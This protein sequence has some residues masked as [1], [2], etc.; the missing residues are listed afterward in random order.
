MFVTLS[1]FTQKDTASY[2]SSSPPGNQ[3]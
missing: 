3:I 2:N 1:K